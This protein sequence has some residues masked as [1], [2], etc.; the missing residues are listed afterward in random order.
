MNGRG[1]LLPFY[2]SL[3]KKTLIFGCNPLFFNLLLLFC[4]VFVFT[5]KLVNWYSDAFAVV[6][7]VVGFFFGYR[8]SQADPQIGEVWKRSL[9]IKD[10]YPP[11]AGIHAATPVLKASVPFYK[12]KKNVI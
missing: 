9:Y 8:I 12:G 2:H 6:L 11:N 5:G 1:D 4:G 3:N 7:F 10:Y